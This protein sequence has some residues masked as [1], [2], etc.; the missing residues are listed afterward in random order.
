M[1]ELLAI[2]VTLNLFVI[3]RFINL[4]R[5]HMKMMHLLFKIAHGEAS[6]RTTEDGTE[7]KIN[8]TNP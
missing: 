1:A 6:I 4:H 8:H 7:I 5:I 2:S 3:W